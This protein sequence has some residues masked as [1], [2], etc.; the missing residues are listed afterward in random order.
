ME[1]RG[2]MKKR[3]LAATLFAPAVLMLMAGSPMAESGKARMTPICAEC[4]KDD[5]KTLWGTLVPGSQQEGSF[6]VQTGKDIWNVRYDKSSKLKKLATVRDLADEKAVKV[7]FRSEG[8]DQVYAEAMSYKSNYSFKNPED[9]ITSAEVLGL[10]KK[11]PKKGKYV[12]F[13]SRG[14]DNYIEGHLP[15]AVLLPN[16]RYQAFKDRMPKDKN[17]LIVAYCRGY[18]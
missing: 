3:S 2:K 10:L 13:D 12:I 4:H 16:Y 11:S 8:G 5:S 18:G 17:T 9:T 1:R 15:G 6:A 7:V 14:Y